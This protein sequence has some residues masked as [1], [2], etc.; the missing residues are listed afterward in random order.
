[1]RCAKV[2]VGVQYVGY[3][4]GS[5]S[6]DQGIRFWTSPDGVQLAYAVSGDGPPSEGSAMKLP[7]RTF[8]C[9]AMSAA[10]LKAVSR[11]AR[12]QTYPTRSVRIVVGFP[13]GLAPDIIARFVGQ[14]LSERLGQAVVVENRPG[15]GSNIGTE[16]VVRASADGHTL[17]LVTATNAFNQTLYAN[18]SFDFV[19]DIA[20][21]AG[22]GRTAFTL[23]VNPAVPAK[24]VPELIAYAKANPGKMN[25][26]SAGIGTAPH[27]FGALFTMLTGI[28]MRHV[29]YRGNYYSD[30]L[31]GQVNVA[32]VTIAPSIEY[33]HAAKLR[34]LGV[35]TATRVEALPEVP[36]IGEFVPSYEASG[37]LGIGAPKDTSTEIIE[38]LNKEINIVI[39]DPSMKTRFVSL[40]VEPMSMTPAE[41]AKF[42]A[43]EAEKWTK[44]MK[45]AGIKPM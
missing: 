25:M 28:E 9:L 18:L 19:H 20:P 7:R 16:V 1:M 40:G 26:A 30:L 22:I 45:F 36:P 21:V 3:S 24:S 32:F 41:F 11:S 6:M 43:I 8:M 37:W 14:P 39:A 17:L 42:I 5:H 31:S 2:S 35:T 12:A 38:K 23:V 27:V 4:S 44:V 29:P 13:A 10:A 33:I 15:A 34:A